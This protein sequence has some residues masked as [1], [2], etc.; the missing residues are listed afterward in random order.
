MTRWQLTELAARDL[1][2]TLDF[3]ESESG[4]VR[5]ERVLDDFV[6]AFDRL[7]A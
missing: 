6:R 3:V 5:A 4:P 1:R 7:A 2:E